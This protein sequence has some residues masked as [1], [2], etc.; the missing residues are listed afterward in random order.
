M[1]PF[2]LSTVAGLLCTVTSL[3]TVQGTAS[4]LELDAPY[5]SNN[6]L[7]FPQN[8]GAW[9]NPNSTAPARISE[10]ENPFPM[11]EC[12]GVA[13][14]EATI[15]QM[16]GWMAGGKLTSRQ[17]V[18]CYLGRI[19][20]LN[21]YVNAIQEINPDVFMIADQ[22]DAERANGTVRGPLHGIPVVVKDNMATKD[23]ME[24]TAGSYALLGSIVPRD[25]H[26]V[27]LLREK[28]AVLLG[29]ATLDEWASMRTNS[30]SSGYSARGGQSRN[31]YNLSTAPGGSSSGS[32]QAVASNMIPISFGTETDG[33][34]IGP[35]RRASL[36][37]FKP[38]VGLTSRAGVIPESVHQDTVGSFGRT[39]K[40][41]I[42]ALE[43]IV[44]VDPRD[45]YTSAQQGPKDGN[46]T[47][48]LATKD[49]LKGAKF[50]LPWLSLWNQTGNKADVPQ[51]LKVVDQL[52]AAGA[53]II[54]GTEFPH[55]KD[56][57]S[58]RGWD[59]TVGP[60]PLLTAGYRVNVD[61]Y[62]NIRDYLSE[63]NNTNLRGVEDLIAYNI[64]YTGIEG[65]IP[66]T[67]AGFRSGQ[68]GFME[69]L[70]TKGEMNSSYYECL[71]YLDRVSRTEGIDAA[72]SYTYPNGT[73][74]KLDALLVP[75]GSG[76]TNLPATA[77]YP[78]VTMPIGVN[79]HSVPVGIALIG[80][81]WS[82]ATL[83]RYGSAIDDLVQGRKKP[84]F[85]EWWSKL[86]PVDYS[87]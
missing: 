32:C 6:S 75:S 26:I 42:Y 14:E 62:N 56:V 54:N 10:H 17:L 45:N 15:D 35:A 1:R 48:F 85:I 22:L 7:Y 9:Q 40:D 11:A 55:Y 84:Q 86:V 70:E 16:Q 28:G 50:G 39:F 63:L 2:V 71:A 52:K 34:V 43:G 37:G 44:G 82:E 69:S 4:L 81:A 33:S 67:V 74:I 12:Y 77:G 19:L 65:G 3:S 59:W 53:T 5:L 66:G 13:L 31:A 29:K 49:A 61:F 78:M 68:D 25:A 20:Q 72:L 73:E 23:K 58:P 30:K 51:L 83:I 36:V 80:T 57:I 8:A 18:Q 87:V 76:S 21:E 47:Q 27:K 38:T 79:A 24:T 41:A 46:Y 64:E 60:S